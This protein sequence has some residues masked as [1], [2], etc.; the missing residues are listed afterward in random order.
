MHTARE[1]PG[2]VRTHRSGSPAASPTREEKEGWGVSGAPR[3]GLYLGLQGHLV[4]PG[5]RGHAEHTA[6]HAHTLMCSHTGTHAHVPK[7]AC[8][9]AHM[10]MCPQTH[11]HTQAQTHMC[12]H[13]CSYTGTQT[14]SD[15]CSHTCPQTCSH[16]GTPPRTDPCTRQASGRG[17]RSL[18]L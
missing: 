15:T 7:H 17:L 4:R 14:C 16:T 1:K 5:Q 6:R 3:K 18:V 9:Q 12:L 13:T 8:P 2:T 10:F 11:T